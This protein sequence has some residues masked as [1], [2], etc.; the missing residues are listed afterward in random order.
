MFTLDYKKRVISFI[1]L[2]F[3]SIP[4][5]SACGHYYL[6][7]SLG[8]S[9]AKL[10]KSSPQIAYVSGD[11]ITD[12][13]PL[14][15]T[16]VSTAVVSVN[17]GY[18]FIGA[19]WRPAVALGLGVYNNPTNYFYNGQVIETP[20]GDASSTLFN[21]SYEISSTRAL[22]E[23]QLTWLLGKLSPFIHFGVGPAW[24]KM[25]SYTETAATST[26]YSALPP[27]QNKTDVNFSYQAGLGISTAFN[28][29]G[30]QSDFPQERISVGYRYVNLG[31]TSFGIR[32]SDY[33]YQLKTGVLASNDVY[34]SYTHL[35]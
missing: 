27:F 16:R 9:F 24:N 34:L 35:F 21:Y 12:D 13:Y 20:A 14:N 23:I 30:V 2:S 19:G 17:G 6:G 28:F 18:E 29:A 3:F 32:N 33:P 26:G 10:S 7:T 15:S 1:T 22:V 5:F 25:S 11:T 31:T 4:A 8:A